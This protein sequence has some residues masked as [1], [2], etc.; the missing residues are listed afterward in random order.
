MNFNFNLVFLPWLSPKVF[1]LYKIQDFFILFHNCIDS[2]IKPI[3]L[4]R[5]YWLYFSESG[6]ITEFIALAYVKL[7][8]NIIIEAGVSLFRY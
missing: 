1:L 7:M 8:L 5:V 2:E 4:F 3:D 6:I